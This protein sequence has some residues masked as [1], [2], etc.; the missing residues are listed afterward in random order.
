[1]FNGYKS[2]YVS[3]DEPLQ[4]KVKAEAV[5][6]VSIRIKD[7]SMISKRISFAL[8]IALSCKLHPRRPEYWLMSIQLDA[9]N[10]SF[11]KL[12]YFGNDINMLCWIF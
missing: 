1:M 6:N 2:T 10:I 9:Y 4:K 7:E 5:I 8:N 11:L 3:S 12:F